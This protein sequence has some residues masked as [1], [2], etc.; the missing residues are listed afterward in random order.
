MRLPDFLLIGAHKAGTSSLHHYL[1]QHPQIYMSPIKELKFFHKNLP[2]WSE[3]NLV[4]TEEIKSY[5]HF[6]AKASP[7]Q[8]CG[9]GTTEYLSCPNTPP[10]IKALIPDCRLVVILRH[11]VDRAYAHFNHR[12]RLGRERVSSFSEALRQSDQENPFGYIGRGYYYRCLDRY[13]KLF[14]TSQIKICFFEDMVANP[15]QTAN[16]I[17]S[18]LDL[19]DHQ[20][21]TPVINRGWVPKYPILNQVILNNPVYRKLLSLIDGRTL[22]HPEFSPMLYR[23]SEIS[24]LLGKNSIPPLDKKMKLLLTTYF[25]DDIVGLQSLL[26]KDL[27]HW[28]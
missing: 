5:G 2:C 7:T 27:S 8:L 12:R 6:F 21:Q 23:F 14:P 4:Y 10:R 13:Y 17:F 11:P 1:S 26:H 28:I 3:P 15:Q 24:T 9:E 25:K 16:E 19:S 20:I 22:F 18:F